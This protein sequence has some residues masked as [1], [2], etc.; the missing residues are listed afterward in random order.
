[1]TALG[2]GAFFVVIQVNEVI[3]AEPSPDRTGILIR[4]EESPEISFAPQTHR[5]KAMRWH[6]KKM[7]FYKP[8]G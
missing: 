4:E 3:R 1:M 2:D 5:G 7:P 8:G 6:N